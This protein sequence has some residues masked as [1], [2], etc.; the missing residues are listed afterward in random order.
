MRAVFQKTALTQPIAEFSPYI[1]DENSH[2]ARDITRAYNQ[3]NVKACQPKSEAEEKVTTSLVN[4]FNFGGKKDKMLE[5][6]R[7]AAALIY[8]RGDIS[9][10]NYEQKQRQLLEAELS[11]Q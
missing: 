9:G 10:M 4:I 11:R 3:S 5:G 1:R 7:N 8:G 2:V 6:W